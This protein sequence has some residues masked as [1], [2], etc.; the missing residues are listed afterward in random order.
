MLLDHRQEKEKK[1]ELE[2]KG[3]AGERLGRELRVSSEFIW[4]ISWRQVRVGSGRG[5]GGNCIPGKRGGLDKG[6]YV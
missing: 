5:P 2:R 6:Q 3:Q 4:Q 1:Y